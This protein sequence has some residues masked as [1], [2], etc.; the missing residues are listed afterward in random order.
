MSKHTLLRSLGAT[1]SALGLAW[2]GSAGAA[3]F[4]AGDTTINL[5]GYTKLDAIYNVNEDVG[6]IAFFRDLE[7]P[8]NDVVEGSTRMH[9]RETRLHFGT[10]TL[11]GGD[12]L[13]TVIETDFFGGGGNEVVTNSHSPRLRHAYA[14]WRGILA[15]QTWSNFMPMVLAPTLDHGGPAGY[16]FNRQAQIRYTTGDLSLALENPES[17]IANTGDSNDPLPD[18]TARLTGSHDAGIY[19]LSGV[20]TQLEVNDGTDS[21][22]AMGF[23]M[24]VAGSWENGDSRFGG[25]FGVYDG[26]NRYLWQTGVGDGD[27]NNGYVDG[28]DNI[29]TVREIG[30]M[31]FADFEVSPGTRA[32][33]TLG[34]IDT[35]SD[36][37]SEAI[38]DTPGETLTTIHANLRWAPEP[39]IMYGAEFQWGELEHRDGDDATAMRLQFAARYSF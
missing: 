17:S 5:S 33:L 1:A 2:A 16:V 8:D 15:G 14:Q 18:V 22:S 36:N 19:S 6:D 27:F 4:A 35:D 10:N 12:E 21:D 38:G 29:E 13:I 37:D 28:S 34:R 39:P 25:Q 30:L 31:V 24:N 26:A 3:E 9:A 20:L 23:G 11:V 7:V 32:G